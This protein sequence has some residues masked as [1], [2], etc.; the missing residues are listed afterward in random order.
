M[1]LSEVKPYNCTHRVRSEVIKDGR[2]EEVLVPCHERFSQNVTLELH[3]E[4][5]H[6]IPRPPANQARVKEYICEFDGA[7]F[8]DGQS[9]LKYLTQ[10]Y[11]NHSHL[12]KGNDR[13]IFRRAKDT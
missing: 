10:R 8:Q 7:R 11:P 4:K 12:S 13:R 6:S 5:K 9:Y 3:C 2:K 1:L